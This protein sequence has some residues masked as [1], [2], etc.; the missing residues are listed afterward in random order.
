MNLNRFL[1]SCE[2]GGGEGKIDREMGRMRERE[3]KNREREGEGKIDKERG[4]MRERERERTWRERVR[5]KLTGREGEL[6][7]R[8]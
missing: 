7:E 3:R 4:R 8:G 5:G 1:R 2:L 6:G